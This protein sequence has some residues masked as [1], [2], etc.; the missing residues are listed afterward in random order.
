MLEVTWLGHSTF[1]FRLPSGEV[2]LTDPWVEGNPRHPAKHTFDRIDIMTISHGHYDHFNDALR[3]AKE[4]SPQVVGIYE[5][6]QWMEQHGAK[7]T[8]PM[9]KGGTVNAGPL[10]VT[11]TQAL[12]SSCI[13]DDSKISCAGEP[14]GFVYH[15][16]DNRRIYFAGDTSA[17]SD[18]QL[19]Q[20]LYQ[21]EIAFL[22]IGDVFT[23]GPREAA[24]ACQLLQ[25]KIVVPMHYGTFPLLTGTPEQLRE[26]LGSSS[27]EVRVL[28]P[29]VPVQI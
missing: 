29:G 11:M 22:P 6:V 18:M 28:E 27:V 25:P 15:L 4:F 14:A 12:H 19:I 2:L 10:R 13:V 20:Q 23:M 5:L 9:N 7:N 8:Q 21:P 16:P 3:L 26:A 24:L 17:F 1:M